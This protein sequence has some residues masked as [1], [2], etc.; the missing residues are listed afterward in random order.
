MLPVKCIHVVFHTAHLLKELKGRYAV[1]KLWAPCMSRVKTFDLASEN[2][3]LGAEKHHGND[4]NEK[5]V[6]CIQ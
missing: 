2:N 4:D 6:Y 3:N 1:I 5:P